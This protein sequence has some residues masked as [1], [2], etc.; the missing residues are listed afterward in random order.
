MLMLRGKLKRE[1]KTR[2]DKS[3][4][5]NDGYYENCNPKKIYMSV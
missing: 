1:M 5:L 4:S 3:E 2:G